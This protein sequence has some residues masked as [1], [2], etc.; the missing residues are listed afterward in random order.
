MKANLSD[1]SML[2][3]P[4]HFAGAADLEVAHGNGVACA[5]LGVFGDDFQPLLAVDR[6]RYLPVPEKIGIGP[7]GAPAHPAPKLVELR[8]PE[9]IGP[10][11]DER[12][13]IGDVEAGLDD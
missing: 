3:C 5:K 4:E 11:Y 6:G 1:V 13:G 9:R 10:V 8:K 2:P 7:G 12:V